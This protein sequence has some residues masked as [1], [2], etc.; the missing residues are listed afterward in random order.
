[1]YAIRSY[2]AITVIEL[3]LGSQPRGRTVSNP[4]FG[5]RPHRR[6]IWLISPGIPQ[7]L[8][9]LCNDGYGAAGVGEDVVEYDDNT[10]THEQAGGSSWRW[11]N[12]KSIQLWP[13]R[14]RSQSSC[15]FH[16]AAPGFAY[17]RWD[18]TRFHVITS[19]S[20]HYTKL[21]ESKLPSRR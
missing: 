2:Y 15:S 12:K 11:S 3:N 17:K 20:I 18:W 7:R 21:Y 4:R 5:C 13:L 16:T 8:L 1:M 19:Y 6:E 9:D 14:M 10:L